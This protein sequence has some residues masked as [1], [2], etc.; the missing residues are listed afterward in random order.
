LLPVEVFA[1]DFARLDYVLGQRAKVR[2]VP[3]VKPERFHFALQTALFVG[4]RCEQLGEPRLVP[5]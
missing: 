1:L 3:Q 2:F 5:R 4:D